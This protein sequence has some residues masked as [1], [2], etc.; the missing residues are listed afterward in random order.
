[1]IHRSAFWAGVA[2]QWLS[3]GSTFATLFIMVSSFKS[4]AGWS[5]DDIL[6][7]YAVYLLSYALAA[8]L[9][10]NPCTHLASKIHTGEFDIALTKPLSPFG[11]E[12]CMG[13][14]FGYLSHITLSIV[15]MIAASVRAGLR[16]DFLGFLFFLY[17][18]LGAVMVQ[19]AFL[20]FS[21][22]FSFF[23][24]NYNPVFNIIESFK[25]FVNYPLHIYPALLQFVLTFVVPI[26][27]IN[28]YP[29]AAI[30]GKN[31]GTVFP[32]EPAAAAPVIGMILFV[33]SIMFWNWALSKYQSTGS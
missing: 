8:S 22:A 17:M 12:V 15:V 20:I 6:F 33:L 31:P 24:I 32:V 7:L 28:F 27:F 25:S 10:F 19:A 9:F 5:G 26:A 1:M 3:Y 2:A 18:L 14:N 23:L 30:L 11:H 21:S 4:L 16:F 13:F 29:A